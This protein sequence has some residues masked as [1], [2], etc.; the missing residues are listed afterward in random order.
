MI[1]ENLTTTAAHL[2]RNQ[3]ESRIRMVHT[4][5]QCLLHWKYTVNNWV[6][7]EKSK[8]NGHPFISQCYMPLSVVGKK[9][10]IF[11]KDHLSHI[12][13]ARVD[14]NSDAFLYACN[15]CI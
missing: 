5:N 1:Y 3:K 15:A 12:P 8:L 2:H 14:E 9:E 13:P 7:Q 10:L 6:H 11:K 4:P